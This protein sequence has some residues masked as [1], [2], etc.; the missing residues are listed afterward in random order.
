M[1]RKIK[2]SMYYSF[3]KKYFFVEQTDGNIER[4]QVVA[5]EVDAL[6]IS[7]R[8]SKIERIRNEKKQGCDENTRNHIKIY[9]KCYNMIWSC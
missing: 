1:S 4:K 6:R 8:L 7:Y 5:R 2:Y 3:L 9:K